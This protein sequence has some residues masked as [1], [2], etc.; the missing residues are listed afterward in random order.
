VKLVGID[1]STNPRDCG[2]C[3]FEGNTV[4]HVG[5]GKAAFEHPDWLVSHCSGSEVVAVDAPF[6]WPELFV[7]ALADYEVG[8]A[9]ERDR[10]RYRYRTTDVWIT[11]NLPK[12][13]LRNVRPPIPL[14]VSTDK[15]G[16]TAMVGTIL[17]AALADE[18]LISPH[19]GGKPRSVIEVYPAVSLWAWGLPHRDLDAAATLETLQAAFHLVISEADKHRLLGSRHCLDALVAALTAREYAGH[20]TFDPPEHIPDDTLKVEGWIRVPNRAI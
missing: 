6:G 4:V 9:L 10:K 3:I 11:E 7:A 18:F 20:N 8:A 19:K 12:K 1:L 13:L 16:A 15:L 2:I 5:W 14:S 17:L